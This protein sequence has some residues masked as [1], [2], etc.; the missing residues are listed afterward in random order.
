VTTRNGCR[1]G[2]FLSDLTG[3]ASGYARHQPERLWDMEPG[4]ARV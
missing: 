2:C 1:Y 3:F 4:R